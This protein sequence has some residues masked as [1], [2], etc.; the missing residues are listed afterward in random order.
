MRASMLGVFGFIALMASSIS[1]ASTP[2]ECWSFVEGM[3]NE[4]VRVTADSVEEATKIAKTEMT[5]L[6]IQFDSVMCK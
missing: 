5:K 1:Q 6:E 3:P 2:Y 4:M